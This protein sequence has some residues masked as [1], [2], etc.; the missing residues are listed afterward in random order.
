MITVGYRN[1][2][3]EKPSEITAWF[4]EVPLPQVTPEGRAVLGLAQVTF[5]LRESP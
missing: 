3:K 4:V 2:G 5:L 1:L